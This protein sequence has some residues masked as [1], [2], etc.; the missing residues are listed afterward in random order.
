MNLESNYN[1]ELNIG[2]VYNIEFG[3]LMKLKDVKF[4]ILVKKPS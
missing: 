4:P 2:E 1:I 3:F